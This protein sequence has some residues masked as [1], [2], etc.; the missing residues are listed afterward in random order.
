MLALTS[1]QKTCCQV[2]KLP[3]DF[4]TEQDLTLLLAVMREVP[5][6]SQLDPVTLKSLCRQMTLQRFAKGDVMVHEGDVGSEFYVLIA[7]SAGVH[8][9]VDEEPKQRFVDHSAAQAPEAKAAK[10]KSRLG[11]RALN[12]R[13]SQ[14]MDESAMEKAAG[15]AMEAA[16][17]RR[18]HRQSTGFQAETRYYG[19]ALSD[20][21]SD[22][23]EEVPVR[24]AR[25]SLRNAESDVTVRSEKSPR[26]QQLRMAQLLPGSSFGELAL[27]TKLPRQS[28]VRCEEK[29]AVAVLRAEVYHKILMNS[30]TSRRSAWMAYARKAPVLR[31]L[32]MSSR[33]HLEPHVRIQQVA[34][35]QK[36][37]Q[38]GDPIQEV[39]FVAEGIFSV[40]LREGPASKTA[41]RSEIVTS[42]LRAPAC[43]GWAAQLHNEHFEES[44][45]CSAAGKLYVLQLK[46]LLMMLSAAQQ[47]ALT[48]AAQ[49]ERRFHWA[50]ASL[51]RA[52]NR[53]PARQLYAVGGRLAALGEELR[54]LAQGGDPEV[55]RLLSACWSAESLERNPRNRPLHTTAAREKIP[56][57]EPD[58]SRVPQEEVPKTRLHSSLLELWSSDVLADRQ[59]QRSGQQIGVLHGFGPA[60]Q[61]NRFRTQFFKVPTGPWSHARLKASATEPALRKQK[62]M[63]AL[64]G[65]D[66]E[67]EFFDFEDEGMSPILDAK[68]KETMR[69][70]RL[71]EEW[72]KS[73]EKAAFKIQAKARLFLRRMKSMHH[74]ATCI[75]RAFRRKMESHELEE[76]EEPELEEVEEDHNEQLADAGPQA[77]EKGDV[78]A[79]GCKDAPDVSSP[80]VAPR[81]SIFQLDFDADT[82]KLSDLKKALS[83]AS[84]ISRRSTH[85]SKVE[86]E[87]H[88]ALESRSRLQS[89]ELPELPRPMVVPVDLIEKHKLLMSMEVLDPWPP[90]APGHSE[91]QRVRRKWEGLHRKPRGST[92]EVLALVE[93]TAADLRPLRLPLLPASPKGPLV[94]SARLSGAHPEKDR[95][96]AMV[97]RPLEEG[98]VDPCQIYRPSH[99]GRDRIR[100]RTCSKRIP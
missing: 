9:N 66:E 54:A 80:R 4:R 38:M 88:E 50:R 60:V 15:V 95:D 96:W 78:A 82:P 55:T 17:D 16:E 7:G 40:S 61:A 85:V 2:L 77:S 75:Q 79:G 25:P 58:L 69:Q 3:P 46:H 13:I 44:L 49:Q 35:G 36:V 74:A 22:E 14:T 21:D 19:S 100:F 65:G 51:M 73:A 33:L 42:L 90:A 48:R 43:F 12:R 64:S 32:D 11:G 81:G 91:L 57:L 47:E 41:Q 23:L 37:C 53:R 76:H 63:K 27:D 34:R 5:H 56:P 62:S 86:Q 8:R 24:F 87:L 1:R 39:F 71:Q 72:L 28:T 26:K 93:A 20:S 6:F 92:T 70:Q 84:R 98:E 97:R 30:E 59:S 89:R 45:T 18:G 10:A 29:C 31:S 67:P 83:R 52:M 94:F 99:S 68:I